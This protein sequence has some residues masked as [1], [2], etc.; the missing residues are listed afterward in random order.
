LISP[1]DVASAAATAVVA[2]AAGFFAPPAAGRRGAGLAFTGA[3]A[4]APEAATGVGLV[5]SGLAAKSRSR[6]AA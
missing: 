5:A 2:G 6:S 4:A 1:D 3:V